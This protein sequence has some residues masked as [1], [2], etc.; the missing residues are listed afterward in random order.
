MGS[1]TTRK[2]SAL[3]GPAL[4]LV[5]ACGAR[6]RANRLDEAPARRTGAGVPRVEAG[7]RRLRE[8][9]PERPLEESPAPEVLEREGEDL[10]ERPGIAAG[11]L[12][13]QRQELRSERL[14]REQRL[15][16]FGRERGRLLDEDLRQIR[17]LRVRAQ[18]RQQ[19][20]TQGLRI[21]AGRDGVQE[22]GQRGVAPLERPQ[23]R[24]HR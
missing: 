13:G 23:G 3:E 12:S 21:D 18:G 6:A 8:E 1:A 14:L 22:A 4:S 19:L 2:T 7:I 11:G 24:R 10:L 20:G 9:R 15:Q 5:V 17:W 16:L